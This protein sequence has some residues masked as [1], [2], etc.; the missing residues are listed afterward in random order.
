MIKNNLND[1]FSDLNTES[2]FIMPKSIKIKNIK[3]VDT[4][5]DTTSSFMPQKGGYSDATSSFMPQKGGQ[6]TSS[7]KKNNKDIKQLISMLS[8]TSY[9][10]Y[11]ANNT[12]TE[13]LRDN[14][15]NILQDG[16]SPLFSRFGAMTPNPGSRLFQNLFK[17]PATDPTTD[18]DPAMNTDHTHI[19]YTCCLIDD[20][21]VSK[22][23]KLRNKNDMT[24]NKTRIYMNINPFNIWGTSFGG[25]AFG[26]KYY[27]GIKYLQDLFRKHK[28]LEDKE[29]PLD[30]AETYE[31]AINFITH[32][33]ENGIILF[34]SA[35]FY[36]K[37][38][39]YN[40]FIT[41]EEAIERM[42]ESPLLGK[43]EKTKETFK[44][45]LFT[46]IET[47]RQNEKRR[48]EKYEKEL[49]EA[50]KNRTDKPLNLPMEQGIA[51]PFEWYK[52]TFGKLGIDFVQGEEQFGLN[53]ARKDD[54]NEKLSPPIVVEGEK[55]TTI[56]RIM[57]NRYEKELFIKKF[58]DDE[59]KKED[60][61]RS[62]EHRRVIMQLVDEY[63]PIALTNTVHQES[64]KTLINRVFKALLFN[65]SVNDMRELFK[66]VID[67]MPT[68]VTNEKGKVL[69]PEQTHKNFIYSIDPKEFEKIEK[70]C[71]TYYFS[72]KA[73]KVYFDFTGLLFICINLSNKEFLKMKSGANEQKGSLTKLMDIEKIQNKCISEC[74]RLKNEDPD[75]TRRTNSY[76]KEL[77]G[78]IKKVHKS[79]EDFTIFTDF[80]GDDITAMLTAYFFLPEEITLN[81]II[82][83]ST[84]LLN[85]AL[86]PML[87][88]NVKK[89]FTENSE[90][91]LFKEK[92]LQQWCNSNNLESSLLTVN[93]ILEFFMSD[94]EKSYNKRKIS[95]STIDI[96]YSTRI[97]EII[98]LFNEDIK[99]HEKFLFSQDQVQV[100][101]VQ[102]NIDENKKG[103]KHTFNPDE[104]KIKYSLEELKFIK[105]MKKEMTLEF[106]VYPKNDLGKLLQNVIVGV[107]P[108]ICKVADANL[109][110][111]S[112]NEEKMNKLIKYIIEQKIKKLKDDLCVLYESIAKSHKFDKTKE[113]TDEYYKISQIEVN[114]Q[115]LQ[116]QLEAEYRK[117]ITARKYLKKNIY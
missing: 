101:L 98:A 62:I 112:N 77:I 34:D 7:N 9:D 108:N 102:K 64:E 50:T 5:S 46:E 14:L 79:L 85:E 72:V 41:K 55:P 75:K 99:E 61:L 94:F 21:V 19:I 35:D 68:I 117:D 32:L 1:I 63:F 8:D 88:K 82:Q 106:F 103:S 65:P 43:D 27:K 3:S 92:T 57:A 76:I 89:Y 111:Y 67:G 15:F 56:L 16:G 66:D 113:F 110:M 40:T 115:K 23:V 42:E 28:L 52:E 81:I 91:L 116:E 109:Q 70:W 29:L 13:Q 100:K 104:E 114:K 59:K 105:D 86:D 39:L 90:S 49:K 26:E 73:P 30:D 6:F 44:K 11:T 12:D 60:P 97:P 37:P 93:S 53:K 45:F 10:N 95:Y 22:L 2:S 36:L 87:D 33:R 24:G 96:D 4:I 18:T 84:A 83:K 78:N 58:G 80:E 69:L 71:S 17:K 25:I 47:R 74:H 54:F 48:K 31:N 107:S 38:F 51:I 20:N